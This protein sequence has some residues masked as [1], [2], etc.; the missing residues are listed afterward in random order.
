MILYDDMS[1]K[2]IDEND[3][4]FG[5]LMTPEGGRPPGFDTQEDFWRWYNGKE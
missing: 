4:T 2:W 5:V 1:E 3:P